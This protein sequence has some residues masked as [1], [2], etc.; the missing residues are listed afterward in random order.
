MEQFKTPAYFQDNQEVAS[1]PKTDL[2]QQVKK[3]EE[4]P[5]AD[6]TVTP[7]L[8]ADDD[9]IDAE[10]IEHAFLR[11]MITDPIIHVP[12]GL[13]T[14]ETLRGTTSP[15]PPLGRFEYAAH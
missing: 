6:R 4:K 10:T 9:E 13:E 2:N 3:T 5:I 11:A 8:H 12:A 15:P 7:V 14:L 1:S